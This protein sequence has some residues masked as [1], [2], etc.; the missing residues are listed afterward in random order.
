MISSIKAIAQ[1][2]ASPKKIKLQSISNIGL[3]DGSNGSSLA[4]QTILGAQANKS[5]S[6][7]GVGLD[8]YRLRS[9]PLFIDFR[10]EFGKGNRN[11][12]IY[13]DVGYNFD[14]LTDNNKKETFIPSDS[15]F[16]GGVYYDGGAGYKIG[17]KD[18]DAILLC[19]GYSYKRITNDAGTGVCPVI[20]PCFEEIQKYSYSMPRWIIKIGWRF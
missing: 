3:L 15:N 14:W 10:H 12:F 17:F 8:Y 18:S 2:K 13:G 1:A 16:G 4:L 6:G 5:F 11:V 19:L 7:I 20:G 9:I